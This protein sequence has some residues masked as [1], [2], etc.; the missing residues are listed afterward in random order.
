MAAANS[1]CTS[2]TLVPSSPSPF[3]NVTYNLGDPQ[4]DLT[5]PSDAS[6]GAVAIN[7]AF[8]GSLSVSFWLLDASN[9]PI[10]DVTTLL[11]IP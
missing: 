8:C 5:W 2:T 4:N 7:P 11:T 10:K 6:L 9:V 1:L 3:S